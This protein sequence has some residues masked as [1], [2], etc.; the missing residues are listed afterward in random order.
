MGLEKGNQRQGSK[1]IEREARQRIL[2]VRKMAVV[3]N[4]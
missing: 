2:A 3:Y 1:G 4:N